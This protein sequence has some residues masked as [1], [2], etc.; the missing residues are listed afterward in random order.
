MPR[1]RLF[2]ILAFAAAAP[3]QA[4]NLPTIGVVGVHQGDLDV[5]GQRAASEMIA[6]AIAESGFFA[7]KRPREIADRLAGRE[8]LVLE[9]AFLGPGRALLEDGRTLYAQALPDEAVP[10]LEQAVST[11]RNGM[12]T[13]SSTRDLWEAWLYLG[14]SRLTAG[15][16]R[17]ARDAFEA[18]VALNPLRTPSSTTFPPDLVSR[19]EDVRR[20]QSALRATVR[21][22]SPDSGTTV[23]VNGEDRGEAPLALTDVVPGEVFVT[24]V[25]PL[26][27]TAFEVV[28][29]PEAG[30]LD[31]PL[32]LGPPTLAAPA[33]TA[34]GRARQTAALYQAVGASSGADLLLVAHTSGGQVTAQLYSVRTDTWSTPASTPYVG[35]SGDEAA[36]LVSELV[37]GVREDGTFDADHRATLPDPLDVSTN[38]LLAHVLVLPDQDV[39]TDERV[40]VKKPMP[41]WAKGVLFGALGAAV[42]GGASYGAAWGLTD[43]YQG[44]I[45]VT[46]P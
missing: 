36:R 39:F 16:A 15:D 46:P 9:E 20:E 4:Q 7:P 44:S 29:V 14:A 40:K 8:S 18:A 23:R 27:F 28:N 2:G 17:G 6:D 12:A 5:D 30:R 41:K 33:G 24:G 21:I 43:P 10:V 11:L 22:T 13:A 19:Y 38:T 25:S 37:V 26:G 3:A 45:R 35:S 31:V 1:A 34:G 32:R 42:V